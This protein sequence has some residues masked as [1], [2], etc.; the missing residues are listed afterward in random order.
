M[1]N[2][3]LR[4]GWLTY[5]KRTEKTTTHFKLRLDRFIGEID[6]ATPRRARAHL[7]SVVG[8]DTQIGA[9][10]AAISMDEGFTVE[11][12]GVPS[13]TTF[14]GRKAQTY[15]GSVQLSDRKKPLRHLIGISEDFLNAGLA[16]NAGKALMIDSDPAF[17]W[18]TL[19]RRQGLPAIPEW[20][21]WFCRQLERR[22]AVI[23]ILG[24]GCDPVMV[25]GC[26]QQFLKW[27]SQG[28]KCGAIR[29]PADAGRIEWPAF[30]LRQVLLPPAN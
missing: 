6:P 4:F 28:I 1:K 23:P 14:L 2:A 10:N 13:V 19:V 25:R 5:Y 21:E 29:V 7:L 20:A 27:L 3:H 17:M 22:R 12:P 15:K 11:G 26:K 9:V 30:S 16:S 8:S 18:S 24:I